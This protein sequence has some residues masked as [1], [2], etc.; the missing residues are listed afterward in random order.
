MATNAIFLP[1]GYSDSEEDSDIDDFG[2]VS[3]I[4]YIIK[5]NAT[6]F[7]ENG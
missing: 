7:K 4:T 3:Y 2:N 1:A 6:N 5:T